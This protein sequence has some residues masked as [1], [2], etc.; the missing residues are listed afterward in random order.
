MGLE[1]AIVA[2][3]EKHEP[4]VECAIENML[5]HVAPAGWGFWNIQIR[6]GQCAAH[7]VNRQIHQTGIAVG[8]VALVGAPI[9]AH[10]AFFENMN[11][12]AHFVRDVDSLGMYCAGVAVENN[13]G[14]GVLAQ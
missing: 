3:P 11:V 13:D 2:V 14:D 8:A 4:V 10:V 1:I 12:D 5:A 7:V 9:G 6:V